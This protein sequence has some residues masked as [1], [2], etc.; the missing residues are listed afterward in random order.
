MNMRLSQ[1]SQSVVHLYYLSCIALRSALQRVFPNS[2]YKYSAVSSS[3]ESTTLS[4][5]LPGLFSR[6][7]RYFFRP[8]KLFAKL[9]TFL[10]I[11]AIL[12]GILWAIDCAVFYAQTGALT[13]QNYDYY[14][15]HFT[16]QRL[17]PNTSPQNWTEKCPAGK[18]AQ[19]KLPSTGEIRA[20][21][22]KLAAEW[23]GKEEI[24]EVGVFVWGPEV[25]T[26]AYFWDSI[27]SNNNPMNKNNN[28]DNDGR[29]KHEESAWSDLVERSKLFPEHSIR[30]TVLP[31]PLD[32]QQL[33]QQQNLL[34]IAD[35]S[36]WSMFSFMKTTLNSA[37]NPSLRPD[38]SIGMIA[39]GNEDCITSP[40]SL[41]DMSP[42]LKFLFTNYGDCNMQGND[43]ENV[44][45]WPLG[46][47]I[48]A[49]FPSS[50]Q[51][52]PFFPIQHRKFLINLMVT[53]TQDKPTRMQALLALKSYCTAQKSNKPCYLEHSGL[54]SH[55]IST[56]KQMWGDKLIEWGYK[57]RNQQE[58][59]KALF[60]PIA[61]NTDYVDLLR[62]SQFTACPLGKNPESYRV[63][64]A[65]MAGSLP[66]VENYNYE[67]GVHLHPS[68]ADKFHCL[69]HQNYAAL[70][71]YKP[72]LLFIDDWQRDLPR[73]LDYYNDNEAALIELQATMNEW[74]KLY[75]QQLKEAVFFKLFQM[76]HRA[77][78]AR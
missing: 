57:K 62:E 69:P 23:K 44:L 25:N 53:Y 27:L 21:L 50:P 39:F 38:L 2:Q 54:V 56:V 78:Q 55:I 68:Y 51:K 63:Y 5:K 66:I 64:E 74:R 65:I 14:S 42:N 40:R 35:L 11:I 30:F 46:P 48:T 22:S 41:A 71:L 24:L 15:P 52:V 29:E 75:E 6:P 7:H 37:S 34:I 10:L 67:P 20:K 59:F 19:R 43:W 3:E 13:V 61:I 73:L 4:P 76:A 33:A 31:H 32:P 18:F 8:G 49:G 45:Y 9:C 26:F 17:Y 72:P 12:S 58:I 16:A 36:D 77:K 1:L 60:N 70:K 47:K 28:H